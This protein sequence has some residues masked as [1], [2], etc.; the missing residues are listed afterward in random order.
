MQ[1]KSQSASVC[2]GMFEGQVLTMKGKGAAAKRADGQ[3]GDLLLSFDVAPHPY[4]RR[5]AY[6]V[7]VNKTIDFVDAALGSRVR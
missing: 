1:A 4:F 5:V 6:D 2:T 3:P 7:H